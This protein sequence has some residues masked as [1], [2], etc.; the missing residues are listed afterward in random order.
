MSAA[1]RNQLLKTRRELS[2]LK[3]AMGSQIERV[4]QAALATLSDLELHQLLGGNSLAVTDPAI[5][6]YREAFKATAKRLIG[7]TRPVGEL[8]AELLAQEIAEC[9]GSK[10][11]TMFPDQGPCNGMLPAGR[12]VEVV[13]KQGLANAADAVYVRHVSGGRSQVGFKS[14]EAGRKAYE[15]TAKHVVWLG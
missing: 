14:Y 12:I 1:L 3:A 13:N 6:R 7:Q 2:V 15:G 11:R 9:S 4:H 8:P 10:L 5:D